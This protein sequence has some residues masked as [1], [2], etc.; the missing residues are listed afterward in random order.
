M[1]LPHSQLLKEHDKTYN[2]YKKKRSLVIQIKT[3]LL[4]LKGFSHTSQQ[5]YLCVLKRLKH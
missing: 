1:G 2:T 4:R 3:I 5:G